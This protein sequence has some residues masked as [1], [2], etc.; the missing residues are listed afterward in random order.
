MTSKSFRSLFD[1]YWGLVALVAVGVAAL[2]V[3]YPSVNEAAEDGAGYKFLIHAVQVLGGLSLVAALV[4]SWRHGKMTAADEEK[5]EPDRGQAWLTG[6]GL[7]CLALGALIILFSVAVDS[8]DN[9]AST[10][11]GGVAAESTDQGRE[12]FITGCGACHKLADADSTGTAGPDLDSLN[13]DEESVQRAIVE[14]GNGSGTMPAE[15]L[16]GADAELVAQYVA[17]ASVK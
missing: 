11:E 16:T 8:S 6:I 17:E 1:S 5:G 10:T 12:L 15:L 2:F 9:P 13:L 4:C 14:G 7:G 3:F